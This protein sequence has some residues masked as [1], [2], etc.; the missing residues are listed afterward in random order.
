MDAEILTG[1]MDKPRRFGV[2]A[3][4]CLL[5]IADGM[6]GHAHGA[7]ASRTVLDHLIA[8]ADRLSHPEKCPK[9]IE[10]AN[11]HLFSVMPERPESSGMGTTL[12]GVSLSSN[13]L[14]MFNVG[15]SRCYRFGPGGLAQLS[16]DDVAD[17]A[18]N[19]SGHRRSHAITQCLGGS[20]FFMPVDPH[21]KADVSLTDGETILLCSDGLTDM[22]QDHAI[23]S[24][25]ADANDCTQAA[26]N[27]AAAALQAGGADNLSIVV[28]R[29][30]NSFP[31]SNPEI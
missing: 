8:D 10:A 5:M 23:A 22:V 31:T 21:V 2:T 24:I 12:A 26:R 1:D 9:A 28:A 29:A 20:P 6:G 17:T 4:N 7:L 3:S 18:K 14:V 13:T 15:D 19:P 30:V 11:E 25:L 27:L 16:H